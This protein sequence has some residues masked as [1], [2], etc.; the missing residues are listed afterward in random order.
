MLPTVHVDCPATAV[1]P[2]AVAPT[3]VA[4][5]P[6]AAV[7]AI[8]AVAVAAVPTVVAGAV[9]TLVPTALV[10]DVVIEAIGIP[11][12][13]DMSQKLVC[14]GGN[15]AVLGVHGKSATINLEDMWKRN[16]TT[17]YVI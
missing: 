4:A 8:V 9:A 10:V 7:A 14:P 11:A 2:T 16:F 3:A 12:G 5:M 15:I 6:V 1:A 17:I 13:W